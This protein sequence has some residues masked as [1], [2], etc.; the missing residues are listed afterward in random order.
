M[1]SIRRLGARWIRRLAYLAVTGYLGLMVGL[2]LLPYPAHLLA[3]QEDGGP[4]RI[5]DRNGRLLYAQE[6]E[7]HPGSATTS[8]QS[9]APRPG[10]GRFVPLDEIAPE[11]VLVVLASEDHRFFAHRGVDPVGILRAAYLNLRTGRA[12]YGGS[13][14]TMQL[15]RMVHSE[16]R[17]RNLWNKIR[18]SLIAMR[19]ERSLGKKD[20]LAHYLNRA[21]YGNGA[22]GIDAAARSY[23]GKPAAALS[24]GE[25]TFL[26]VIPRAPTHYDPFRHPERL[27]ARRDYI[28]AALVRD[29]SL[30]DA[31]AERIRDE[32]VRPRRRPP[33]FHAP[34]FVDWILKS[35]GPEERAKGGTLR[36]T[37]ELGL[38]KAMEARV[39]E[40]VASMTHQRVTQAGLVV[41]DTRS[42]EVLAMV[43]SADYFA[44][45]GAGQ[46]NMVTSRRH[47]GS[48]LKPFV[49]ALAVEKGDAPA[50]VTF[51]VNNLEGSAYRLLKVT[52]KER[53]PVP[54]REALAGSYNLAAVHVLE[55]V[56]VP[57]LLGRLRQAGLGPLEGT[58]GDYGLQLALGSPKL[59]LLDLA[60]AYGFLAREGRVTRPRALLGRPLAD[61][62]LR[63]LEGR[64]R[65]DGTLGLSDGRSPLMRQVPWEV[66]LFSPQV[67][68]LVADM[69]SDPQARRPMFGEE[70]PWDL[71]FPVIAKT[72]TSQGFADTVAVAVTAEVTVAA[73]AGNFDG[74][75]SHGVQAMRAAAPLVAD[76]LLYISAGLGRPL[77]LPASPEGIVSAEVCPLSGQRPGDHCPHRRLDHFQ[78]GSLPERTCT[79]HR[80]DPARPGEIQVV[81]PPA[82][83]PWLAER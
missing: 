32:P 76:A 60:S 45:N 72:G 54:Y 2:A 9:L 53:G 65:T 62:S 78:R 16:G 14:V 57:A 38:Q 5:E 56:G 36:T 26:A 23:F 21:F 46:L 61:G 20:I 49:Y 13:T 81:Y 47:P 4:L 41:L 82:L 8:R 31:Q 11:A 24:A 43:G 48:A 50:T 51:D 18:E 68:W 64:L 7:T 58:P 25:A 34:H 19:M 75:P 79:W 39:A 83:R 73:W 74:R 66:Q 42:G 33:P 37:L 10:R 67:S 30:T 22:H 52:Q 1:I 12:A 55:R 15:A 69:L 29:G 77:T 44:V 63:P 70:L 3:A 71:P 17:P 80:P 35:I 27:L 6:T 28:L 59:R 40:H